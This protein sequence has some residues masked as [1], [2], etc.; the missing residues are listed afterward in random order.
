MIVTAGERFLAEDHSSARPSRQD[1]MLSLCN[2][3][4]TPPANQ[5]QLTPPGRY[6]TN[7]SHELFNDTVVSHLYMWLA[8]DYP[9]AI[10]VRC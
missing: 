9:Q 2:F 1:K 3:A 6:L 5:N 7:S 10:G 8:R 4:A